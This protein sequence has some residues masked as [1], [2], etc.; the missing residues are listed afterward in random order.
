MNWPS[1]E[2]ALKERRPWRIKSSVSKIRDSPSTKIRCKR[3][4]KGM[5]RGLSRRRRKLLRP[6]K[7]A[8]PEFNKR[9]MESRPSMSKREKHSNRWRKT[10]NN[11]SHSSKERR[12]FKLKNMRILRD[13]K[14]SS[15]KTMK[16]RT[17]DTKNLTSNSN[18]LCRRVNRVS[19]NKSSNGRANTT[20]WK[21]LMLF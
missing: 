15:S 13:S 16:L 9:K 17:K 1:S 3:P 6:Y 19:E 21:K 14:R 8:W 12:P 20:R 5:R 2:L 4:S 11:L 18:R 7:S 10:S